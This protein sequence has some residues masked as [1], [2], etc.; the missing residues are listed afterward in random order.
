MKTRA[1][2]I[3]GRVVSGLLLGSMAGSASAA[4]YCQLGIL[5][6]PVGSTGAFTA[7][8]TVAANTTYEYQLVMRALVNVG[9]SLQNANI[10]ATPVGVVAGD[11]VNSFASLNLL[12]VALSGVQISF[13]ST[14]AGTTSGTFP[15]TGGAT[16]TDGWNGTPAGAHGG[17]RLARA[18]TST[19]YDLRGIRLVR[20]AGDNAL[21]QDFMVLGNGK[22]TVKVATATG[23]AQISGD[24]LGLNPNGTAGAT[25]PG[26]VIGGSNRTPD[27]I[28]S[29]GTLTLT[30]SRT[31]N[32]LNDP[33]TTWLPLTLT[34]AS[35]AAKNDSLISASS[36]AN[37]LVHTSQGLGA[38][39]GQIIAGDPVTPVT[40]SG[41][42][43]SKTGGTTGNG[44]LE[45]FNT[46]GPVISSGGNVA[47]VAGTPVAISVS[48]APNGAFPADAIGPTTL[49]QVRVHNAANTMGT[50]VDQFINVVSAQG[51][52]SRPGASILAAGTVTLPNGGRMLQGGQY[53]NQSTVVSNTSAYH[54]TTLGVDDAI[55]SFG[56]AGGAVPAAGLQVMF[57]VTAPAVD[58]NATATFANA[59]ADSLAAGY[60]NTQPNFSTAPFAIITKVAPTDTTFGPAYSSDILQGTG[61]AGLSLKSGNAKATET[62]LLSGGI[63]PNT[64]VGKPGTVT[65]AYRQ[66][67]SGELSGDPSLFGA[68]GPVVFGSPGPK[69]ISDVV[70]VTGVSG[71]AT[72][73]YVVMEISYD[74]TGM[75]SEGTM[76][77]LG[78]IEI[79]EWDVTQG[80][81]VPEMGR[82]ATPVLGPAPT[83][84]L[85][86]AGLPLGTYGVD[87]S[88]HVA[89]EIVDHS[90]TFAV[91]PEPATIGLLG[92]SALGLTI[93]RRRQT[94]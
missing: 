35:N 25:N 87:T 92:L 34:G 19:Y 14:T 56:G 57:T 65:M 26:F 74:T 53:Y 33:F 16:L 75:T 51:V 40:S 30:G 17:L 50:G 81:W 93:R 68:N 64:G 47:V 43:V 94:A 9:D 20:P 31:Q 55:V 27:V 3:V 6:R 48:T 86:I 85:V 49:G 88:T 63:D 4:A 70:H 11:G 24:M 52:I 89:W 10:G 7:N 18:G 42:T 32:A 22:F 29:D 79:A 38:A 2:Q 83:D 77:A 62:K 37:L 61:Y 54:G 39:H 91:V 41:L 15:A 69:I 76:A 78:H 82:A 72:D 59:A 73:G 84:P 28:A 66:A 71:N 80:R 45:L 23:S 60:G 67:T 90:G 21:P 12:Q 46:S 13:D 36:L 8:L 1:K 5:A 58:T 44:Y